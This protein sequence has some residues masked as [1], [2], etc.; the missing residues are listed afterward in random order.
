MGQYRM[1][2]TMS[3]GHLLQTCRIGFFAF[4]ALDFGTNCNQSAIHLLQLTSFGIGWTRQPR[5][6]CFWQSIERH[7]RLQTLNSQ[8][9]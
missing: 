7:N 4:C 6:H 2:P 8:R 1:K 3:V 5:K 9:F